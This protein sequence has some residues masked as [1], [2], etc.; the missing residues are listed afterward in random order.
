MEKQV[1]L[2]IELC[3]RISFITCFQADVFYRVQLYVY[4]CVCQCALRFVCTYSNKSEDFEYA[5]WHQ[6]FSGLSV[7][8]LGSCMHFCRDTVNLPHSTVDMKTTEY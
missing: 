1:H 3:S 5:K 2:A 8:E 7:F 6:M 4:V